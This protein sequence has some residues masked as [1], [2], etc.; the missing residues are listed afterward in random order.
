MQ[1]PTVTACRRPT[2]KVTRSRQPN[3]NTVVLDKV[4]KLWEMM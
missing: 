4:T 3:R 2:S 1:F